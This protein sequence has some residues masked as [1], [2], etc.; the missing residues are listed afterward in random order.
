M[1]TVSLPPALPHPTGEPRV[2]DLYWLDTAVCYG[3]DKKVRR[4]VVIVRAPN[5]PLLSDAVVV[6]RT[7]DEDAAGTGVL[8]SGIPGTSLSRNGKFMKKWRHNVD[9]RFFAMPAVASYAGE[10]DAP[11]LH[12]VLKMMGLE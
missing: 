2:G 7:S 10:L 12:D 5:P 3:K 4:P 1:A 6:A 11:A 9:A 8:H